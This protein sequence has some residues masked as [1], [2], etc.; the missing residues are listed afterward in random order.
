MFSNEIAAWDR[1]KLEQPRAIWREDVRRQ[2]IL[3]VKQSDQRPLTNEWK[4]KDR[5]LSPKTEIWI[6]GEEI[7]LG[8]VVEDHAFLRPHDIADDAFGNR[9]TDRGAVMQDDLLAIRPR[10]SLNAI[11]TLVWQDQQ[12]TIGA[13][14]LQ[15]Y[16][17]EPLDQLRQQH[18][19]RQRL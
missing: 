11:I 6:F 7:L 4:A 8:R 18:F 14:I 9:L 15:G 10:L 16:R 12:A 17:H 5:S 13:G 19:A 3:Q 1:Q 2:R